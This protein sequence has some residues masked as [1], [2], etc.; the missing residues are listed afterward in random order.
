MD[1]QSWHQHND[2]YLSVSLRWLR[3][4]LEQLYNQ[5]PPPSGA[6][7]PEQRV[8]AGGSGLYIGELKPTFLRRRFGLGTMPISQPSFVPPATAVTETADL[9]EQIARAVREREEAAQIEPLPALLV[10]SNQLQLS[11]FERDILLLCAA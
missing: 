5:A 8:D 3:L 4:R 11:S 7:T 2:N 6:A 9:S 1:L 10:L